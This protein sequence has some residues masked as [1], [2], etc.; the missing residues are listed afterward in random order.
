M[1]RIRVNIA[2]IASLLAAGPCRGANCDIGHAPPVPV[3]KNLPYKD[4][5]AAVLASGWLPQRGR[6]H[7]DLSENEASFR[8]RG[9]TELQFCRL[10][11]D[12]ACRF[13]FNAPA[14]VT[15]WLTTSGDENPALGTQATVSDAKLACS[16]DGDPG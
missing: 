15:L 5:R 13:A 8:E 6:P 7:N 9:F 4:A 2:L 12:S 16:K 10:N 11:A 3:V 14:G 1:E